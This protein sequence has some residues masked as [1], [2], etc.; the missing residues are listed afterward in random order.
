[1]SQMGFR[2]FKRLFIFL[3]LFFIYQQSSAQFVSAV[4]GIDGLTCSACSYGTERSIRKLDFVE[5]V[6][7][8]LNKNLAQIT[9]KKGSDVSID[10]LVRKVYDA[11]F[12]VRSVQAIY[13]FDQPVNITDHI[14]KTGSATFYVLK[15]SGSTLSSD[16]SMNFIREK[17]VSKKELAKWKTELKNSEEQLKSFAPPYYFVA[18]L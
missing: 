18:I 1:M 17:Y 2:Q 15:S 5:N 16:V 6:N 10:A 13:H 11:G 9:F 14:F 4:I 12:S 3:H 7:M 8:D